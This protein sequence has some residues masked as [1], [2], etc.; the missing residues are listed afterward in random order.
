[1]VTKQKERETTQL[2]RRIL[3]AARIRNISIQQMAS[4]AGISY[5]SIYRWISGESEPN[6]AL[7]GLLSKKYPEISA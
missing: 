4:A 3:A 5:K 2:G 6:A 1:M 7:L